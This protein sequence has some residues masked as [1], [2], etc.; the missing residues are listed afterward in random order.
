MSQKPTDLNW[1]DGNPIGLNQIV[2]VNFHMTCF[3]LAVLTVDLFYASYILR[4][5]S[6]LSKKKTQPSFPGQP[7]HHVL[8]IPE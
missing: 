2:C 5:S 7:V 4:I 6:P 8:F 3:I 1:H